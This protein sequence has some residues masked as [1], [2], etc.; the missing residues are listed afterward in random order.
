MTMKISLIAI[1]PP[2]NSEF[3]IGLLTHLVLVLDQEDFL[4]HVSELRN[5][6]ELT[7]RLIEPENLDKWIIDYHPNFKLTKWAANALD[8]A[9]Q[10][11]SIDSSTNNISSSQ[12]DQKTIEATYL[13]DQKTKEYAYSNPIDVEIDILLKRFSI[14]EQFRSLIIEAVVCGVITETYSVSDKY[15][16]SKLRD[17]F[18]EDINL[19]KKISGYRTDTKNE[20]L[21]DRNWYRL[22]RDLK[23]K[24]MQIAKA[25]PQ[26]GLIDLIDYRNLIK[27]QIKRYKKFLKVGSFKNS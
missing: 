5:N 16:Q 14:P 19:D 17:W 2:N 24:P 21:R 25:D 9:S 27:R 15:T 8:N 7:D 13:M 26:R 4:K 10:K 12:F 22:S 18:Y 3:P 20:L 1:S 6:W 23:F 11:I